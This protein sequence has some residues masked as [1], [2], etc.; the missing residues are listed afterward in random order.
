MLLFQYVSQ[1]ISCMDVSE[2][3]YIC[4]TQFNVYKRPESLF[5]YV[6][7][8]SFPQTTR[9]HVVTGGLGYYTARS[10]LGCRGGGHLPCYTPGLI[11]DPLF[12][13]FNIQ[14]LLR[15]LTSLS[16]LYTLPPCIYCYIVSHTATMLFS[17]FLNISIKKLLKTKES[18]C[19][20]A[21]RVELCEVDKFQA[22]SL[23]VYQST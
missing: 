10:H 18:S 11:S 22:C 2:T 4:T 6:M 21:E 5:L 12:Q 13:A 23:G 9:S 14:R 3:V 17:S 1:L 16:Y 15:L 19:I 20:Y 8:Y 7:F